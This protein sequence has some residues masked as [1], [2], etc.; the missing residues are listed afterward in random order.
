MWHTDLF[1][2]TT[3][4]TTPPLNILSEDS[5]SA[6]T[7]QTVRLFYLKTICQIPSSIWFDSFL[8][9][10]FSGFDFRLFQ[11]SYKITTFA[12]QCSNMSVVRFRKIFSTFV[13]AEQSAHTYW[14]VFSHILLRKCGNFQNRG[15]DEQHSFLVY[16]IVKGRTASRCLTYIPSVG[17]WSVYFCSGSPQPS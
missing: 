11:Q 13:V 9:S 17:H 5:D 4:L 15:I 8:R 2:Y 14:K 12:V 7:G 1:E 6:F 3:I 16:S 10:R